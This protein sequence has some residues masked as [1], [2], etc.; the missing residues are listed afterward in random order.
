MSTEINFIEHLWGIVPYSVT[1]ILLLLQR[2]YSK[3]QDSSLKWPTFIT[4]FLESSINQIK[5]DD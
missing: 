1:S 2:N 3:R 4:W 5:I